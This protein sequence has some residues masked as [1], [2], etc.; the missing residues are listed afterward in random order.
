M[1]LKKKS[2]NDFDYLLY[3]S[4]WGSFMMA[5]SFKTNTVII[6]RFLYGTIKMDIFVCI[7]YSIMSCLVKN[8]HWSPGTFHLSD[9]GVCWKLNRALFPSDCMCTLAGNLLSDQ[10]LT[11][12]V[13]SACNF[14]PWHLGGIFFSDL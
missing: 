1:F 7:F 6:T 12:F 13:W 5:N 8:N 11:L 10:W 4:M 9:T 3:S 14:Q 2:K